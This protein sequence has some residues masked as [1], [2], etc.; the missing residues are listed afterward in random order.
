[1]GDWVTIALPGLGTLRSEAWMD[2][3]SLIYIP[4][5]QELYEK[6][7]PAV[8]SL[9]QL[10]GTAY[11]LLEDFVPVD[12][13][14]R[15]GIKV[16]LQ[17]AG[18]SGAGF[19]ISQLAKLLYD[20]IIIMS[21]VRRGDRSKQQEE[22][23]VEYLVQMGKNKYVCIE[24]DLAESNEFKA[25]QQ[26]LYDASDRPPILGINA[27]GGDSS[28]LLTKLLGMHGTHVTYGGM[29]MKPVTIATPFLIFK[30][31]TIRG[32]WHSRWMVN[33]NK[34]EKADMLNTLVDLVLDKGLECAPCEVFPLSKY[35][36][37]MEFEGHQSD[38]AIRH[39]VVFDCKE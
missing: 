8:A 24:E 33:H 25:C 10:G 26:L 3:S 38:K 16:V 17:N 35:K 30:D 18:N 11:R 4:R 15:T 20:D 29:G 14:E 23:M 7:G 34:Q 32:Y 22:E 28:I 19:M 37:A 1:V 36:D 6:H 12:E 5:G 9:F 13:D 2:E 31:L 39:K 21:F 27:V